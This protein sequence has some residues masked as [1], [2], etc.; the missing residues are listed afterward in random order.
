MTS[1][2]RVLLALV[3]PALVAVGVWFLLLAPQ[4]KEA[5]RLDTQ[6]AAAQ[7]RMAAAQGDLVRFTA[8]RDALKTNLAALAAAGRAVPATAAVPPLLRR[9][10]RTARASGV[11]MRSITTAGA[12]GTSVP[13]PAAAAPDAGAPS[14]AASTAGAGAP[15]AAAAG[16]TL[17]AAAA[18]P[19]TIDV[20]LTFEGR[21]FA[22]RRLL[23]RLDRF[24]QRQGDGVRAGGRL[25]SVRG[26]DLN[27]SGRR[28]TAQA[29]AAVYVLPEADPVVPPEV[30]P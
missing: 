12:S 19:Q 1:R 28:L 5:E 22:L 18:Q 10:E 14:G 9:L 2:D 25:I 16:T 17:G 3:V 13:A 23:A 24:V 26:L 7:T 29:Q 15:S 30:S 8:A 27:A 21:Y 20:T 6:I 4:R 11:E